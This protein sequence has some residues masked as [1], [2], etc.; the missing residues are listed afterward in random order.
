MGKRIGGCICCDF[1]IGLTFLILGLTQGNSMRLV[2][3]ASNGQLRVIWVYLIAKY[4]GLKLLTA[5]VTVYH[6][7]QVDKIHTIHDENTDMKRNDAKKP[8]WMS[9]TYAISILNCIAYPIEIVTLGIVIWG[10][11]IVEGGQFK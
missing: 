9:C 3:D 10:L 11:V 2:F 4:L 5:C 8:D 1:I 6:V 7:P